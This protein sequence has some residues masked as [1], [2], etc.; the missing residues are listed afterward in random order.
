MDVDAE[1]QKGARI[2]SSPSELNF[3]KR[4]KLWLQAKR[5]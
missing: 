5:F 3:S 4:T 2:L 1:L